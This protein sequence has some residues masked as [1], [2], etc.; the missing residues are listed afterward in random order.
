MFSSKGLLA[1]SLLPVGLLGGTS[2]STAY[3]ASSDA[4][5]ASKLKADYV[6][7]HVGTSGLK[8]DYNRVLQPGTVLTVHIDGI[9]ADLASTPQAI[10]GTVITNNVA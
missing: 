6:L 1:L 4:D 2:S 9:Y 8:Y 7:S 10:V 3:A 5:V